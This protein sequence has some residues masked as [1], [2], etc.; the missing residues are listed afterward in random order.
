T[1]TVGCAAGTAFTLATGFADGA[2]GAG[3]GALAQPANT[4]RASNEPEM[5]L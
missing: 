5:A 4:L 1:C 2:N 3:L